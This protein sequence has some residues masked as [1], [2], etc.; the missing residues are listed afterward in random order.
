MTPQGEVAAGPRSR[1]S[2]FRKSG[3]LSVTLIAGLS[4]GALASAVLPLIAEAPLSGNLQGSEDRSL[5]LLG[6][7]LT[8]IGAL[9]RRR[10]TILASRR[11]STGANG[12]RTELS[13]VSPAGVPAAP[14]GISSAR[15]TLGELAS[16]T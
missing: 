1:W 10:R 15:R 4:V 8:G 11:T 5:M 13:P 3:G 2:A 7:G 6:I 14:D 12:A 9:L 16:G